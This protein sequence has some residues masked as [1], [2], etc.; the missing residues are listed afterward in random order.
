MPSP[1]A[2]GV[3]EIIGAVLGVHRAQVVGVAILSAAAVVGLRAGTGVAVTS[4]DRGSLEPTATLTVGGPGE[5]RCLPRRK[6][7]WLSP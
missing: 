3:G 2:S 6:S 5:I 7:R 1:V 4:I